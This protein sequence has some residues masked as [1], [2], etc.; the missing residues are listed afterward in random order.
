MLGV[1]KPSGM[2]ASWNFNGGLRMY[3]MTGGINIQLYQL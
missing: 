1:I 3:H 2:V